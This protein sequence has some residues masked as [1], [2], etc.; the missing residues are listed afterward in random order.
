MHRSPTSIVLPNR[1]S[2]I[3]RAIPTMCNAAAARKQRMK[4]L[5]VNYFIDRVYV[6]D[7]RFMNIRCRTTASN[8][9][10]SPGLQIR[11][12]DK[13]ITSL[14]CMFKALNILEAYIVCQKEH[15]SGLN[16]DKVR[17][18][19]RYG[20]HVSVCYYLLCSWTLVAI[21]CASFKR[22]QRWTFLEALGVVNYNL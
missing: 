12:D 7:N 1:F 14:D 13:S 17:R 3:N 16:I 10:W 2:T 11:I 6:F 5:K 20:S 8:V 9:S 22:T 18:C 21:F 15:M 4:I 19:R